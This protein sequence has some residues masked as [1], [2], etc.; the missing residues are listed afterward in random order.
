VDSRAR[1]QICDC[2]LFVAAA[3]DV[4]NGARRTLDVA[5]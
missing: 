3:D 1:L 5:R 4:G 2:R